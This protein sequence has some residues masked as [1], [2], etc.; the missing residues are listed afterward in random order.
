MDEGPRRGIAPAFVRVG[1]APPFHLK[2][3]R[4]LAVELPDMP[5]KV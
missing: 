3:A 1:V 5:L 2:L 4:N